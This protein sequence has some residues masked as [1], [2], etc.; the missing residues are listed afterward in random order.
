MNCTIDFGN[1]RIKV[2]IFNKNEILE[3]IVF[4]KN[5]LNN[6]KEYLINK[7]VESVILSSVVDDSENLAKYLKSKYSFLEFTHLTKI[8]IINKYITPETLGK[9]RLAGA[10][11]ANNLFPDRNILVI[12][13]GTCIKYDFL[14]NKNEYLGGAI[15]PGIEMRFKALHNFTDK[16]PLIEAK[17]FDLLIGE[18]TESS[19]LSGVINGLINE[20]NETIEQY[21]KTFENIEIVLTGGEI[22]YFANKIKS[23]I[24]VDANLI[25]K[26]LN[27]ILNLNK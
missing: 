22:I 11:A 7:K 26:G 17:E 23:S 12:D 10:I 2:G 13:A 15:S 9:D 6:M 24:F 27:V 8:P 3:N 14:N 20:V 18:T 25:L 19:I 5:E 21:K 16:L 1:T 4:E